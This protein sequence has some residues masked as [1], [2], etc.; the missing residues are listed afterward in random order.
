[1][2]DLKVKADELLQT[3]VNVSKQLDDLSPVFKLF[4]NEYR[5]IVAYS[6]DSKGVLFGQKWPEYKKSTSREMNKKE[7]K[8]IKNGA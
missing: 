1:M 3:M 8:K 2:I 4:E 6:F 7:L 5:E